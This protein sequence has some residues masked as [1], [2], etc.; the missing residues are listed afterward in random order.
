MRFFNIQ[1]T[2]VLILL[3]SSMSFAAVSNFNGLIQGASMDEKT[4][5]EKVLEQIPQSEVA[6]A[7]SSSLVRLQKAD[8]TRTRDI[9]VRLVTTGE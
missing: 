1:I 4:L 5:H 8:T 7:Y 3:T 9:S 6:Q 2:G